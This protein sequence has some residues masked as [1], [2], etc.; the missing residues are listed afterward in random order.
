MVKEKNHKSIWGITT[1]S[2]FSMGLGLALY[3][4]FYLVSHLVKINIPKYISIIN[5][6]EVLIKGLS[7]MAI[8]VGAFF[9]LL[10]RYLLFAWENILSKPFDRSIETIDTNLSKISEKAI[11]ISNNID[12][13]IKQRGGPLT[14]HE[15]K[16]RDDYIEY[17][18]H[19]C[20]KIYGIH[21][22]DPRSLYNYVK[23]HLLDTFCCEPHQSNV[24]KKIQISNINALPETIP[25]PRVV[26]WYEETEY[27]IHHVTY[28]LH[29]TTSVF[30]V[31]Y[32][33]NS[34]AP[35]VALEEWN[36]ALTFSVRIEGNYIDPKSSIQF[37]EDTFDDG[38]FCW[39]EGDWINLRFRK[40][41]ILQ[42]EFTKISFEEKSINSIND[43]IYTMQVSTPV[44]GVEVDF[45]LPH[46]YAFRKD[47]FISKEI[48]YRGLPKQIRS[49]LVDSQDFE[50]KQ[51]NDNH[52]N[53]NLKGWVLPGIVFKIDW[54]EV[55]KE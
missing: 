23:S 45:Q 31:L 38:F 50:V 54:I 7:F 11:D 13:Y 53:I 52:I 22:A 16:S 12:K 32:A 48:A 21:S 40:T 9:L 55:P 27:I 41:L 17:L 37:K 26:A 33:I 14:I 15:C 2:M 49:K 19:A 28:G 42:R 36:D 5:G 8:G 6:L 24:K 30:P 35:G 39:K 18:N 4:L 20:S 34:Y 43:K 46:N 25:S 47:R 44:Y 1:Y 3:L 10:R 29:T 51:K